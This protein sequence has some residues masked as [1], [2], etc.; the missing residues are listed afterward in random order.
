EQRHRHQGDR[1]LRQGFVTAP[2]I[3]EGRSARTRRP[4]LS[5]NLTRSSGLG[6]GIAMLWFSLLVLIPL[7]AVV[8]TATEGGWSGFWNAITA[9]Q[10]R[11]AIQLTV[12]TA[13]LVTVVNIFMGTAI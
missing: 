7:C 11:S 1:G 12:G 13:A 5:T 4:T 6:L 9:E 3:T 10:T 8:V 2:A